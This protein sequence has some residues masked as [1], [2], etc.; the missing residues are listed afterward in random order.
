MQDV[1]NGPI[2]NPMDSR[3][4]PDTDMAVFFNVGGNSGDHVQGLLNLF[5]IQFLMII[6]VLVSLTFL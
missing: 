3:K 2:W 6:S 5:C 4:I 1:V